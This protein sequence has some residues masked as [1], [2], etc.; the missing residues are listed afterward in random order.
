MFDPIEEVV[1]A[2]AAGEVVVLTD[3]ADREN[4]GDLICAGSFATPENINFMVTHGRGLLCVPVASEV[5]ERLGLAIPPGNHDPRGTAFT[6]SLDAVRGT[7]TGI[8]AFDRAQTVA[9]MLRADAVLD[10]FYTPGHMFP[11][12][13]RPG[14]VLERRGHTEGTIDLV[15]LAGL[16]PVGLLCEILNPD[17]TMARVPDLEKFCRMY[18]LKSTTV[19]ALAAYLAR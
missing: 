9:E 2:L 4:E 3:D 1:A 5:A 11:L 16:P 17:G 12:L 14:G 13:A 15:R 18:R 10:D 7:T 19:E 6:Q 8:S